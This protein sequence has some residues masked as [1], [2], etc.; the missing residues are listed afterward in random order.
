MT[1]WISSRRALIASGTLLAATSMTMGDSRA[2]A[3]TEG[4]NHSRNIDL[5]LTFCKAGQDRDL[6]KQVS[7]IDEDSI[8]PTC[9][10]RRSWAVARRPFVRS[11]H[12]PCVIRPRAGTGSLTSR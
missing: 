12:F 1:N 3:M 10:T 11:D 2:F 5:I 8:Y 6:E 7:Y 4:T 9:R